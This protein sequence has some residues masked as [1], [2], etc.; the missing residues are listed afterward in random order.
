M[1][2]DPEELLAGLCDDLDAALAA[3]ESIDLAAMAQ[4]HGV[5]E[6]DAQRA[7][8]AISA[9]HD[10]LAE[11]PATIAPTL[12]LPELP[13]DYELLGE[14]GRGGMGIVYHAHQKSLDRDLAVKVLRPGEL[15]FGTAIA[16]FERE[17]RSL[18]RL[19]H[20]HIVSVHEVGKAS[21]FV[22]FTMD[23]IDGRTLAAHLQNGALT[24]AQSVRLMRQLAAAMAYAHGKGVVH[25]D[26]KPQN[27]LID[28][29]D[30]AFVVDFGLARDLEAG[31]VDATR[32]GQ[33]L[34]TPAYMSPEQA[35]GDRDKIGEPSDI[36]ALG[37]ILYECLTGSAPFA[38][39]PLAQL[40]HAV[41]E[42]EPIAARKRNS[43]VPLDLQVICEKAMHK[44]PERRYATVQAFAEDLERF[45]IGK[46][47]LARRPSQLRRA[48]Q[49]AHRHRGPLL[50]TMAAVL[51]LALFA[52]WFVLP[53]IVRDRTLAL[54]QQMLAAGNTAGA[55]TAYRDA[56]SETA[57]EQMSVKERASYARLLLDEAGSLYLR[58]DNGSAEEAQA[59][60]TEARRI[61][62]DTAP[63]DVG[64]YRSLGFVA[65]RD[66]VG[67]DEFRF[68]HARLRAL[69]GEPFHQYSIGPGDQARIARDLAGAGAGATSCLLVASASFGP[70][71]EPW[72]PDLRKAVV[73]LLAAGTQVPAAVIANLER[74]SRASFAAPPTDHIDLEWLQGLVAV[75]RDP[76][77]PMVLRQ[78]AAALFHSCDWLPFL[79]RKDHVQSQRSSY[80]KLHVDDEDLTWLTQ[81]WDALQGLDRIAAYR[82]RVGFVLARMR[83]TTTAPFNAS[84]F[85][86]DED[87][88]D[89]LRS[90]TGLYSQ[91][92]EKLQAWWTANA[93]RDPRQWLLDALRWRIEPGELKPDDI[94]AK[95]RRKDSNP[96][97]LHH[98]LE[99]T[100]PEGTLVP[101]LS[102]YGQYRPIL[103][104]EL[105]LQRTPDV[106]RRLRIATL[107]V[108]A[109]QPLPAI[110]WQDDAVLA[111]GDA[112]RW[113]QPLDSDLSFVD[114][115]VGRRIHALHQA[116]MTTPMRSG[117]ASLEWDGRT[118]QLRATSGASGYRPSLHFGNSYQG[119]NDIADGIVGFLGG[120]SWQTLD[121][122][123]ST[124]WITVATLRPID[125]DDAPWTAE[126]WRAAVATTVAELASRDE[127]FTVNNLKHLASATF[128]PLPDKRA[129]L[130][131]IHQRMSEGTEMHRDYMVQV[132][133]A[134][135][136]LAGDV[137]ALTIDTLDTQHAKE[138]LDVP[139][140][141]RLAATTSNPT[142]REH[143]LAQL[144]TTGLDVSTGR[145]LRELQRNGMALPDR[146]VAGLPANRS[147]TA[148]FLV[149]NWLP[150]TGAALN[151][152][153][154]VV[155]LLFLLRSPVARR[156]AGLLLMIAAGLMTNWSL[157]RNG[158]EWHPL[159]LAHTLHVLGCWA[160][161][162]RRGRGPLWL[163]TCLF[164]TGTTW[165]HYQGALEHSD[166]VW[167]TAVLLLAQQLVRAPRNANA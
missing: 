111:I 61:L 66:N 99:L 80:Y 3:G 102:H 57:K 67:Q 54:G 141:I 117:S 106:R 142:L 68:E 147:P 91:D 167:T 31:G 127:S 96:E 50:S 135:L 103:A 113:Q 5:V 123:A 128:W 101:S 157:W 97:L 87:L 88:R 134:S 115:F 137:D 1:S 17:A 83:Q 165:A 44:A 59:F 95:L 154:A 93:D 89:W 156:R 60:A 18:A 164:W 64:P 94:L 29:N 19:R 160:C 35:L 121:D 150:L 162:W 11:E 82:K 140:W 37:A 14:L 143:A 38:G 21:G 6:E 112:H 151:L 163:F 27:I 120:V 65:D 92:L 12:A 13:D 42:Q 86:L 56:Y 155:L 62:G 130:Q 114:A 74:L 76:S 145:A 81:C 119:D 136:L 149:H 20:R 122:Y 85:R 72:A 48:L 124:G 98:L 131:R 9:M 79:R 139:F 161:C 4:R 53:G 159:W 78:C 2:R 166:L 126:H 41:I 22:Y 24:T 25:R 32:S 125:E 28:A 39:M 8:R 152:L 45:A 148:Q 75:V 100:A 49:L 26:L 51:L 58:S 104:W 158:I 7:L 33:L 110:A 105:A 116:R 30:D 129:E 132:R 55:V 43:K 90:H 71:R 10:A 73:N 77:R 138:F 107:R 15:M 36:Y 133:R 84:E 70:L 118:V 23:Y 146:L 109:D 52:W 153:V 34:G 40:M 47:I 46:P 69:L 63:F 108:D 144:P 16:R